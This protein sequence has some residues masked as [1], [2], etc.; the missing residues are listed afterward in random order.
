MNEK[1]ER[2]IGRPKKNGEA[3]VPWDTVDKLLVHGEKVKTDK[4]TSTHFPSFR[5]LG[6]RFDVAHSSI[7][8]Y[9]Q[10]HNCLQ[11]RAQAAKKVLQIS[12]EKLAQFRADEL[13]LKRDDM[14]RM[15]EKFLIQ[16]EVA[17]N[18]GRVRCDNPTDF[19][20]MVRLR[21]FIIGDADERNELVA[22]LTLDDLIEAH[23]EY[24]E[25]MIESTPE[26]RGELVPLPIDIPEDE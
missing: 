3:K 21:A 4:G 23:K 6:K 8:R 9:S 25:A 16:F 11:R 19:N 12:D 24:R 13:T 26:M 5:E 20:T 18:E 17:L 15:L 22:G 1:K 14:L 2:K 7:A 10:Q